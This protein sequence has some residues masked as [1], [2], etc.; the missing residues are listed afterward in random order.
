MAKIS[1]I[2]SAVTCDDGA[3]S[4]QVITNDVTEISWSS[5]QVLEDVTGLNSVAIERLKLLGDFTGE[6]T[7][8]F[9]VAGNMSH[10][11][12]KTIWSSNTPRTLAIGIGTGPAATITA[13]VLLSD[14]SM[15]VQDGKVVWKVPFALQNGI[16]PA[17]S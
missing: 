12:F 14:Y 9:N 7:G 2:P 5:P 11:V 13:E 17:W 15:S 4:P 16:A 10:A 1:G 8:W 6:M 3:G